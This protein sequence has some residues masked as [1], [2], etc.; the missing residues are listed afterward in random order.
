MQL[1]AWQAVTSITAVS[2]AVTLAQLPSL[3]WLSTAA[4]SLAM[5]VSALALMGAAA[6][7]GGRWR[8]IE[9]VFGGLDRVYLAHKWMAIYAVVFAAIH[10]A[11]KAGSPEWDTASILAMPPPWTRLVRQLSLLA[12]FLIV[13]LALNRKIPYHQWRWWHKLSGPLFL[14]VIL[15]W[16]SFKSPI[17]LT[18]SAGLWLATISGLGAAAAFYK[19]VLYPFVSPHAEYRVVRATPGSA[20]LHL[21]LEP[22][23]NPISF[24]PGQFAFIS[25]KEEGLR[26]PHPFTIASAADDKGHVHFVIRDLG[27]YTHKLIANTTPGMHATVYAPFGR[28]SRKASSKREVWIAGGVGISPFIAWLKDQQSPSLDSVTLFYFFTPGREFPSAQL[29]SELARERGAEFV[30]VPGGPMSAEFAQRFA[31]LARV[32]GPSGMSVSFCGPKGLLQRV[33]K[34]MRENAVPDS[35]IQ[36][37]YFEFR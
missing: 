14:I 21:E 9:S 13:M 33:Q 31:E 8:V 25:M 3:T 2:V 7:L 34:L 6:I 37:E 29:I 22:V 16:L 23:K 19:L 4:L 17:A 32:A 10:F 28:F 35:N 12:L 26:E 20:A 27:D 30:P 15:H 36:Y 18:S 24:A 5:G 1:R 11:F